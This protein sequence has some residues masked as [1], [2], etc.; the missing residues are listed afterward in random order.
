[1]RTLLAFA[2]TLFLSAAALAEPASLKDGE[3]LRGRFVQERHLKGF[4]QPARSEGSFVVVGGAGL[5]WRAETPF[6]MSTVITPAGLVQSVGR[7]E[8]LRLQASRMPFL[9][10]LYAMMSG[11]VAGDWTALEEDF[12]VSRAGSKVTMKPKRPD[13]N[14][15]VQSIV[16][17]VTRLVDEVDIIRPEGDFDH[18]VFSEQKIGGSVTAEETAILGKIG[19]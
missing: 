12:T 19:R 17:K 4:T 6:A 15:P 10:R 7:S 18:L 16:A 9:S 3:V 2:L 14:H 13:P 1:M 11:A 5:I 8:T